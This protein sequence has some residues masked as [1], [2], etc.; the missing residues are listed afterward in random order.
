[1]TKCSSLKFS[2]WEE[3]GV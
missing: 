2:S 1:V 3:R